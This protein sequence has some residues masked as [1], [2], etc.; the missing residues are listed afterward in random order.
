MK[1]TTHWGRKPQGSAWLNKWR[2]GRG[3]VVWL[4]WRPGS[5]HNATAGV[6]GGTAHSIY[7]GQQLSLMALLVGWFGVGC[8]FPIGFRSVRTRTGWTVRRSLA[9]RDVAVEGAGWWMLWARL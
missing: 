7:S 8:R 4:E 2:D 3:V 6:A 5:R 9:G 1:R